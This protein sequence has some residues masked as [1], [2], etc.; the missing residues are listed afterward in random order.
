M[1]IF[2]RFPYSS[3]HE[4]N[5]DFMLGKAT[6]IAESLQEI[7]THKE[8]A[9]Q[10]A[11][12]AAQSAQSAAQAAQAA[13]GSQ[14]AA[15][16]SASQA[17][18]HKADAEDAA[19]RAEAA[20]D[21]ADEAV[22]QAQAAAQ[23]AGTAAQNASTAADG[24]IASATAAETRINTLA[25]S[26]PEDFTELNNEVNDLKSETN[27]ICPT[28]HSAGKWVVGAVS[29]STGELNTSTTVR[30]RT[31]KLDVSI[32]DAI[33][34]D[35]GYG[36]N[37][38]AWDEN[39]TYLG[40][41][42]GNSFGIPSPQYNYQFTGKYS[43]SA[44]KANGNAAKICFVL[45]K[46]HN[47]VI[48]M[49]V[50]D[51]VHFSAI[52][53]IIGNALDRECN[54]RDFGA[55]GDGITD[56]TRAIQNAIDYAHMH[57]YDVFIPGGTYLIASYT[58]IANVS[59]GYHA[60]Q[61]YSNMRIH[62]ER[63]TV[64]KRGSRTVQCFIGT[65]NGSSATGYTGAEN[66]IIDSITFDSNRA[67]YTDTI[68]QLLTTH[69]QN[70]EIKNC[71]FINNIGNWHSI[72]INSSRFVRVHGCTFANNANAED[73]QLDSAEGNGNYLESD[74]TVC[75]D[76]EIFENFFNSAG[77]AP[78]IGNHTDA[79]H[80][81]IRIHENVFASAS[82]SSRGIIDFVPLT[83]KIDIYGNTFYAS[84][85]GI[86]IQNS[87]ANNTVHDNRFESVTTPYTGGA[88]AYNNMV[89]DV[90]VNT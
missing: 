21:L 86:R 50:S 66:I 40:Y 14:T 80:K 71:N 83:E 15:G 20:S 64:L 58:H 79:Q 26:L 17:A 73:I 9:E 68:T 65:S 88:I 70:I 19:D 61:V 10:A 55:V 67:T 75:Q 62:G 41:W 52:G 56:D 27:A 23:T 54:V 69:A 24:A 39:D 60:L 33:V 51:Y 72:E 82:S 6:E 46:W 28:L 44:L 22:E 47:T 29:T 35:E 32:F 53:G 34:V 8:Q 1:G 87:I 43:L 49:A 3:T 42:T 38:H 84:A 16:T 45:G 11:T 59:G 5:L 48:E 12:N 31:D 78:A 90:L 25:A 7:D 81:N 18:Q 57:N 30:I 37:I 63:N 85:I 4:M 76:I 77:N 89:N 13:A 74:G 36:C 2:D